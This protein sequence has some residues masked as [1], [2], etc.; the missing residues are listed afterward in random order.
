MTEADAA[1]VLVARDDQLADLRQR[2]L[3]VGELGPA[4]VLVTGPGGTGSSALV[5]RF[6]AEHVAA[7]RPCLKARGVPWEQ[8]VE[9]G[10]LAQ[11]LGAA[12]S[13]PDVMGAADRIA[14]E[15]VGTT[16]EGP[17]LVVVDDAA[18]A[19]PA[20]L[21]ALWSV[22]RHH[23]EA[24]MLV[25]LAAS[26]PVTGAA[27]AV[28][29][30]VEDRIVLPPLEPG[31][32]QQL[33][34][35]A[36]VAL[37]PTLADRLCRFT[38]GRPGPVLALL[39]EQPAELWADFEPVLPAPAAV[40]AEVHG[41]LAGSS[42]SGRALAEAV[43]VLG[44]APLALAASLAEVGDPLA[45][46]DEL[47]GTGLVRWVEHLGLALVEPA[48]AMVAAAVLGSLSQV[49]RADLHRRS[50][51]LV[52][53]PVAR[54]RHL[55]AASPLP[56]PVLADELDALAVA[57]AGTGEWAA[58]A[59]LLASAARMTPDT[60]LREER[61][62]RAFDALVG[63]GDTLGAAAAVA[64]VESLRETPLR[65]AALGY[66]AIVRGRPAEAE[67]R[68]G[69]AWDLVHP[70]RDPEVAALVCHRWVLHSLARCRGEDLVG[71]ADR[72]IALAAR[73]SP[74]AVETAAI[75]GLGVAGTGRGAQALAQYAALAEEVGHGAQAQRVAMGRGWTAL[76]LDEVD[77]ARENLSSATSTDFLGGSTRISL[78]AH[79]WLARAHFVSGEW[80]DALRAAD[81]GELLAERT[82]MRLIEP[83]LAWT[84]AQVHAL[85]GDWPLADR[86]VRD[87]DVG[88]RDYEIMRVAGALAR[89]SV[90]EARADY[91]AVLRALDP[92]RQPWAGGSV[93][94][95]GAWP[96][97]DVYANALAVEGRYDD[98]DAFLR[99]H[100]ELADV[101]GHRSAQ[102]RLGYARGR[103][104]GGTGDLAA[105]RA[106]F[107]RSAD[108]LEDLP[109]PYDRARV[110]FAWGQ[111]PRR[112]GKRREA[113]PLLRTARDLYA[114]LG[115]TTYVDRCDRELR[116]GGVH[117]GRP[118]PAGR[119]VA[120]L[121]PQEELV[122]DLVSRGM[123]NREVG[124]ELFVSTKTVQ[125]HLTRIY[126]KLG[127]RS[128]GEL[129]A[130]RAPGS[131]P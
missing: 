28:L 7:G 99:P 46:V 112:A 62:A 16:G 80:D 85:R 43:A 93:D 58:V 37:H 106:A 104:L 92:L 126:A 88:P 75:R 100:E 131:G 8:D 49:R 10:V 103:L 55:V 5:R 125:Y 123:T 35:R 96:W 57:R 23:P 24:R 113:D 73:G 1:A 98:A 15:V 40:A 38:A 67:N 117:A 18:H 45:P 52:A 11:L 65:N 87:A 83:L 77:V 97:P 50:A 32:V 9:Q 107:Q 90:A 82:G 20:S 13:A 74:A 21:T 91:A 2:L 127:I 44:R 3:R 22:V 69:R 118:V 29:D 121:T 19:D 101:R 66:L 60:L 108:L 72:A 81:Q 47:L 6:A 12:P 116:A 54:L 115:A 124:T 110:H 51:A 94:E 42:D 25:V 14:A 17:V 128:R 114:G 4:M 111:T 105:A 68:L 89:A 34:A 109:L 48:D 53:D 78:W 120:A 130:Q 64:E 31:D 33:A 71:W 70:D 39:A 122:A 56:D 59:Q 84:R 95:P 86:A 30:R 63:S 26:S 61:L 129:A 36:G 119:D 79:A 27:A 102:V 41:R 76:S